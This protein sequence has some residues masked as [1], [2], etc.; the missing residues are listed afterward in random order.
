MS[1]Q[2]VL[3]VFPLLFWPSNCQIKLCEKSCPANEVFSNE[4]SQCQ[5]TC[6]NQK[7]NQTLKCAKSPGCVCIEGYIRDQETYKCIPINSCSLRRGSKHCPSNE[8]Y[9]DCDAEC[10]KTCQ[11][12]NVALNCRCVSGCSC[13]TGYVRSD[14]NFQCIPEK[15]CSS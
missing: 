10:F 12:R 4:V 2:F 7:F 13:R 14:I 6:F 15:L 5:N 1:L 3:L 11:N 9:S 8:F